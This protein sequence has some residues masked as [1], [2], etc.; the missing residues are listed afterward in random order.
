MSSD[1]DKL[2]SSTDVLMKFILEVDERFVGLLC[3]LDVAQD[4]SRKVWSDFGKLQTE[5]Y[6]LATSPLQSLDIPLA[7]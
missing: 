6:E 5:S 7:R 4:S 3:E 1:R 2:P